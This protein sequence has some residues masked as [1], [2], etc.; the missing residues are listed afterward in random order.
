MWQILLILAIP[1]FFLVVTAIAAIFEKRPVWFFSEPEEPAAAPRGSYRADRFRQALEAGFLP[2]G[3]VRDVRGKY[4]IGYELLVSPGRDCFAVIGEGTIWSIPIRGVVLN[5][6]TADGRLFYSTDSQSCVEVDLSGRW[7][8]QL[9]TVA[10]FT[11]LW[12]RHQEWIAKSGVVPVPFDERREIETYRRL[13]EA[14]FRF[15]AQM[16]HISFVDLEATKW[17]Y[18]VWSGIKLSLINYAAGMYRA[19]FRNR[20]FTEGAARKPKKARGE[21][22]AALGSSEARRAPAAGATPALARIA[23]RVSRAGDVNDPATPRPLLTLAEFF[24]GNDVIG[25][26]GCNLTPVV[27]P[28]IM[29]K[30]LERIAARPEVDEVRVQV[31]QFDDPESWPFSDTVWV[32]TS[33]S[34]ETVAT[35]F[36]PE[37][38]P[39]DCRQGWT[40]GTSFEP[41]P[42]RPGM[43]PVGCWW[44]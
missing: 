12:R 19:V 20:G 17:H 34:P 6:P 7:K 30:A 41:C 27:D 13:R 42:I 9:A 28:S 8:S 33:V 31:S 11:E 36:E 39:D 15:M 14:H 24:D 43:H 1:A 37:L 40:E 29:R 35:W 21:P 3:F 22:A 32:I 23:A 18:T 26:I 5:T 4:Q 16:G 44:D 10:T 25:S 38:R 2:L